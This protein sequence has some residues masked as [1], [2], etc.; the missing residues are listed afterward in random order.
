[1][2]TGS[3]YLRDAAERPA[4]AA[5]NGESVDDVTKHPAFSG[6]AR[7]IASL[8]DLA[9]DPT[10]NLTTRAPETGED[11]LTAFTIPR[12]REELRARR[13]AI[14]TWA[15]ETQGF[16]GRGPDHVAGF[17]AG[18]AS[19]A[20]LFDRGGNE[21]SD[22]VRNFYSRMLEESLYLSY[23]ILPPQFNRAA[24]AGGWEDEYLQ[25]GV[26][27]ETD[28]GIIVRGCQALGTAAPL[29]DYLFVSCIKPL[30][31]EDE[32]YANSFVVPIGA[33]GLKLV[34]RRAYAPGKPSSFDYP[35]STRF[36]ESDALAIFDDVFVPWEHV[37]VL[38]DP[39]MLRDQFFRTPAH[40]L[41][42]SQAQT[43][44]ATKMKFLAG[45]AKKIVATNGIE[46]LPPVQEKLGELASLAA[47]VEGMLLAAESASIRD[48]H[49]CER[50]NPRFQYGVMAM[51]S[52][53]YPRA[54]QIIRELSGVGVMQLPS[55]VDD[56][57]NPD[58]GESIKQFIR[59]P[60][61]ES[62][63]RI[64]LF[65]LAWDAIGS[66]FAGRHQQ[67]EMFYA[68]APFIVR[69]YSY[70]NYGYDAVANRVEN[71]LASYTIEGDVA[72]S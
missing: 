30:G 65:K 24:S 18:F 64:K 27:R 13:E 2:R 49:G 17:F 55:S 9:A 41:G 38:R 28:G 50:P 1:M 35:L 43:R 34:C 26:V 45:V 20:D 23:T 25:V 48:D 57:D 66:E 16:V 68:G 19:H 60:G 71:F 4:R 15:D 51:Q 54:I 40:I 3:D 59:S 56:F 5:I 14:S 37:F 29:S 8:Y 39:E 31:D 62:E 46:K 58:V 44:L 22:N 61:V 72:R 42:N 69:G 10:R 7:T 6:M 32:K 12:S 52:E 53:I 70:R 36:D 11:A 63:E 47:V 67:Y 33:E 21:F